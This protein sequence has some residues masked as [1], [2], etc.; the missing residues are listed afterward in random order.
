MMSLVAS[1]GDSISKVYAVTEKT[2]KLLLIPV[3]LVR[4]WQKKYDY[5][6][7]F[8]IN[9]FSDRYAELLKALDEFKF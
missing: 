5:G 6:N 1:F 2:S 4:E 3:T 7:S 9:T 8:V